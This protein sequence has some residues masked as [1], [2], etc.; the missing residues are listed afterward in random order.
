MRLKTMTPDPSWA[1]EDEAVIETLRRHG[2]DLTIRV[3]GGDWC[4]DCKAL[5]PP[6]A[7]ALEE[8]G[9]DPASV[10][11]YPV[12]KADDGT[13]IG[14]RVE[15]YGIEYIPTIVIERDGE[16]LVRFVESEPDGPAAYLANALAPGAVSD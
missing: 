14:P 8:A 6:F 1:G 9:I 16:E 15:E 11:Q 5:L 3:W 13:K 7:A 10:D 2:S 12:E 4:K